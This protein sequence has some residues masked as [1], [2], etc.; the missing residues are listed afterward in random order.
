MAEAV[1][2]HL[3]GPH[4]EVYSAGLH[5]TGRVAPLSLRTLAAHGYPTSGLASKGLEDVPL[6]AMDIIV[7][8][9]GDPGLS[10]LPCRLTAEKIAWSIPDP[11]GEDEDAYE[12][13]LRL[14]VRRITGLLERIAR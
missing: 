6:E 3:A 12:N 7:S 14:L 4:I 13:T 5:P 8:L 1:T 10:A 2:R 9:M 11:F